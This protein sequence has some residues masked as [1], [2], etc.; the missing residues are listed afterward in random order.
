MQLDRK[1]REK[2]KDAAK[3]DAAPPS[4]PIRLTILPQ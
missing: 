4:W 3:E 2:G 1:K